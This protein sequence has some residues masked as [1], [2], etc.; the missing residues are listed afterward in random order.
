MGL[1]APLCLRDL[2][3]FVYSLERCKFLYNSYLIQ[4]LLKV[5]YHSKSFPVARPFLLCHWRTLSRDKPVLQCCVALCSLTTGLISIVTYFTFLL[6][7]KG[8]F[9]LKLERHLMKFSSF[10]EVL[11]LTER[12]KFCPFS[13]SSGIS[14]EE[15]GLRRDSV[16]ITKKMIE[17]THWDSHCK[18]QVLFSPALKALLNYFCQLKRIKTSSHWK[19][20]KPD[21]VKGQSFSLLLGRM[22]KL[23]I[24]FPYFFIIYLSCTICPSRGS[25][26]RHNLQILLEMP[27]KGGLTLPSCE[28]IK[29]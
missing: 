26:D 11:L 25:Q 29:V 13:E 10:D 16:D 6:I 8:C 23:S 20:M 1:S 9:C 18:T 24:L 15:L 22:D 5:C 3:T 7:Q 28:G 19:H 27:F 21:M 12:C 4:D 14:G 17:G 2:P